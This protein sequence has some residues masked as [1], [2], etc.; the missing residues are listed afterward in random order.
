MTD[1]AR[2]LWEI[3]PLPW[4]ELNLGGTATLAAAGALI[5]DG[6]ARWVKRDDGWW[7]E[8]RPVNR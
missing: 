5:R 8:R 2:R 1:A 4:S 6:D 7:L 3:L